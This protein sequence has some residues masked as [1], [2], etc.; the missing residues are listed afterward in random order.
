MRQGEQQDRLYCDPD[1]ARFYDLD[2]GWNADLD[3]CRSMAAD[4][5]S[6]LDLGCGTGLFLSRL[7]GP[8][9]VGADPAAAML[10]IARVRPG[11][12]R[13][14]WVEADARMLRLDRAFDLIVLT[15]HAFQVF[16]TE[17]DRRAVLTTIAAH[18]A[19]QGRFIFDTRSPDTQEWRSWQ[20]EPSMREFVDPEFGRVE[21]WNDAAEDAATG[22]VTY[23]THYRIAASGRWFSA[24]SHIAFPSKHSLAGLMA[25]TG[26]AVETWLGDWNGTV[27]GPGSPE[28]IPIGRLR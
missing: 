20:P 18:L 9:R 21:A 23:H 26:L 22:L 11:G 1:L 19:P 15:G 2:N 10:D 24:A 8:G 25:E 6:V 7:D 27:W 14:E 12:E 17:A 28:I 3:F 13:V 5:R 4:V 16:L